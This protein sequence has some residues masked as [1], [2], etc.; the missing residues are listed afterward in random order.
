MGQLIWKRLTTYGPVGMSY[1]C[2]TETQ[3]H[4]LF[5][6]RVAKLHRQKGLALPKNETRILAGAKAYT[7]NIIASSSETVVLNAR[8]FAYAD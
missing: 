5:E 7:Y 8:S 2:I 3:L 1:I 6:S 4:Q